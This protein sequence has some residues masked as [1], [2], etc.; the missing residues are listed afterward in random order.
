MTVNEL[1]NYLYLCNMNYEVRIN[2]QDID[3][4][5]IEEIKSITEENSSHVNIWV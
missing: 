1:I 5:T 4:I 2:D 3:T